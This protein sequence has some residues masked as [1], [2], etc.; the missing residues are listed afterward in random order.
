M[1]RNDLAKLAILAPQVAHPPF[2]LGA[3]IPRPSQ[4][5]AYKQARLGI[6]E[7]QAQTSRL[8]RTN[9]RERWHRD[10]AEMNFPPKDVQFSWSR[11]MR[12]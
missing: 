2:S 11:R 7:T 12:D 9:G 10:R 1:L 3:F 4:L 6:R 5:A 8:H